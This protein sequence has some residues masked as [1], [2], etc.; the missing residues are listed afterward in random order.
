VTPSSAPPGETSARRTPK[1]A[2]STPAIPAGLP[3]SGL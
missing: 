1:G 3:G 2:L